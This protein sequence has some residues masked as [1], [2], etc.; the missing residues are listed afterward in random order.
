MEMMARDG[1]EDAKALD[2]ISDVERLRE[3]WL[4]LSWGT[5]SSGD[6]VCVY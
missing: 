1:Q 5:Q 3:L 4:F 2:H 6:L